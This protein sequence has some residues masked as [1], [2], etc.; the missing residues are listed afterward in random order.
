MNFD[1]EEER[2]YITPV[3]HQFEFI[4][5]AQKTYLEISIIRMKFTHRRLK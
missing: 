4:A 5:E 3:I 1:K 2:I